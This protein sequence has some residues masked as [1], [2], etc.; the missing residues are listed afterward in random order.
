MM[1]LRS[2]AVAVSCSQL[3][4][5]SRDG[6]TISHP[7]S[8]R[9]FHLLTDRCHDFWS[10][11]ERDDTRPTA[12]TQG[13]SEAEAGDLRAERGLLASRAIHKDQNVG[14]W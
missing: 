9:S 2:G 12:P 5:G 10:A 8:C 14:P 4:Q 6:L 3:Q 13:G 7:L 11:Q 1:P